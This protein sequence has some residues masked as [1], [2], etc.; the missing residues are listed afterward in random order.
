MRSLRVYI[1]RLRE[2]LETDPLASPL[3]QT[4]VG[5]GYRLAES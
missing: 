4:E 3:F 1:L 2:K 5:V